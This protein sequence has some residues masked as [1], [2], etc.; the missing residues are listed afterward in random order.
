MTQPTQQ[1][2]TEIL[3][4]GKNLYWKVNTGGLLKE[5]M[6]NPGTGIL[7]RP[8]EIFASI[9]TEAGERAAELNDPKLNAIMCRL[10]I[11]A[12]SDPYSKDYNKELT[13]QTI[14]AF[15]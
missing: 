4:T 5:I 6:C 12:E 15:F 3:T 7:R 9:L 1:I 11:Y 13:E 8:L 10:A 2:S 14:S